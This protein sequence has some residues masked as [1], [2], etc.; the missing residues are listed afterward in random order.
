MLA[1]R[2][3]SIYGRNIVSIAT[4]QDSSVIHVG[5]CLVEHVDRDLDIDAFLY[6]SVAPFF[7]PS[8]AKIKV[9]EMAQ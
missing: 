1:A 7:E 2:L 8:E 4:D 9:G 5:V 6:D 3:H